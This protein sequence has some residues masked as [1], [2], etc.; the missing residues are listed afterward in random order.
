MSEF[1]PQ[2]LALSNLINNPTGISGPRVTMQGLQLKQTQ[3][4]D[5]PMVMQF[6]TGNEFEYGKYLINNRSNVDGS[7]IAVC[8]RVSYNSNVALER[9][10]FIRQYTD[11]E[12]NDGR[13]R[14][15]IHEIKNRIHHHETFAS[16]LE[17]TPEGKSAVHDNRARV[18]KGMSY[19]QTNSFKDGEWVNSV[20]VPTAIISDHR[21]IEDSYA[22]SDEYAPY[23]LSWGYKKYVTNLSQAQTLL[24]QWG[25]V[26]K[27]RF[28]PYV[29]ESIG[30]DGKVIGSVDLVKEDMAFSLSDIGNF[31][32]IAFYT[33]IHHNDGDSSG[34]GRA[35]V[36]D[37]EVIRA[38]GRGKGD[39]RPNKSFEI[40][41]NVQAELDLYA[42]KTQQ[43]YVD[44]LKT[45]ARLAIEYRGEKNI[46]YSN[47]ARRII[48]EA[49]SRAPRTL[50]RLAQDPEFRGYHPDT[51][52]GTNQTTFAWEKIE[53]YR[54]AITV[55]YPIPLT[56]SGKISDYSGTK[57]II[58]NIYKV[59]DAPVDEHGRIVH[60]MR[61][62]DAQLRRSTYLPLYIIYSSHAVREICDDIF[63][64]YDSGEIN[65]DKAWEE[66]IE[67]T[68]IFN[69]EWAEVTN[70]VHPT[71]KDKLELFDY[72]KKNYFRARVANDQDKSF[73]DICRELNEKYGIKKTKLLL[74]KEDGSKV[75]TENEFF[76][77]N[78]PTIR[79]DKHGREFSSISAPRFDAFGTIT[80]TISSESTHRPVATK[81]ITWLSESEQ[82][83][84]RNHGVG[85]LVDE[86][87]DISNNPE[88]ADVINENVLT[89]AQP[90]NMEE[91]VDRK[92]YPLGNSRPMQMI[93]HVMRVGGDTLCKTKRIEF[94]IDS[95]QN[96]KTERV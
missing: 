23:F 57:G 81:A 85:E 76:V 32:P 35:K 38:S 71:D 60:C 39:T 25:D 41:D 6:P 83:L 70:M 19:N 13:E 95:S 78:I 2:F 44:I 72:I 82:R 46:P 14:I 27:P 31:D 1:K 7:V 58:S 40:P 56:V 67:L 61:C 28:L 47:K 63:K 84:M 21:L 80:R 12:D 94:A 59:E 87:S 66:V 86:I 22:M 91:C 93:Q 16:E 43:Y 30:P 18:F 36:V 73:L 29:G 34:L 20:Q 77:G 8:T 3:G 79:L 37:I 4:I 65:L 88:V 17:L 50:Q 5:Y 92:K 51:G 90:S 26:D 55:K 75:W 9:C 69:E 89:A 15:H 48:Y 49:I 42:D 11:D 53:T 45:H 33:K 24:N 54:I 64:Q 10:V 62:C 68:K 96:K 74:T 52:N